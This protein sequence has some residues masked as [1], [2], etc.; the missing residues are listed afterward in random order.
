[1]TS[2]WHLRRRFAKTSSVSAPQLIPEYRKRVLRE[3]CPYGFIYI[4]SSQAGR[5]GGFLMCIKNISHV[6]TRDRTDVSHA[7]TRLEEATDQHP[8][9]HD[10]ATDGSEQQHR[11][12][13]CS[14]R[15]EL[16]VEAA[17]EGATS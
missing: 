4:Y 14:G 6:T 1:M 17:A 3:R 5:G 13:S 16:S 8:A 10:A 12:Q 15:T 7:P 9:P 2:G 11:P